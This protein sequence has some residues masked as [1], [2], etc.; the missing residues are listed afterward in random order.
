[1][2]NVIVNLIRKPG[3]ANIIASV[4]QSAGIVDAAIQ[5]SLNL[6]TFLNMFAGTVH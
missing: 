4:I 3:K 6:I 1:L 5:F 2:S